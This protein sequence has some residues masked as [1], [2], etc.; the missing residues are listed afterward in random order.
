MTWR[1]AAH[2]DC[3]DVPFIQSSDLAAS[4]SSLRAKTFSI[5][6][7]TVGEGPSRERSY[8]QRGIRRI[9]TT[10]QRNELAHATTQGDQ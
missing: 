10:S 5:L 6:R 9:R 1:R 4:D 3:R 7:A 8:D 2:P